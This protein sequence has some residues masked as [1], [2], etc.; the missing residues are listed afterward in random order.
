MTNALLVT[1]YFT[2]YAQ[3]FPMN[4]QRA[5]TVPKVLLENFSFHALPARIHSDQGRDFDSRLIKE[6]LNMLRKKEPFLTTHRGTL[7]QIASI[8][9][10]YQC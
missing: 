4:N 6:S 5:S 7:S 9:P 2:Q 1:D 10:F 8:L 3:A